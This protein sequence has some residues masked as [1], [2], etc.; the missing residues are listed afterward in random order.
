MFSK[1][2][3]QDWASDN[4]VLFAS[5]MTKI[6][7]RKDDDLLRTYEFRGFPSL[8]ILDAEGN[9]IT[10]KVSRDLFSMKNVVAAAPM[11]AKIKAEIDDGKEIDEK[12]WFMAQLAMGEL[13]SNDVREGIADLGITGDE[14]AKAEEM[15]FVLEMGELASKS[16]G[17]G[18]TEADK[19]AACVA[20]YEAFKAGKRL[21]AGAAPEA[22]VD[23][24]LVDA[25]KD[26]GDKKAF[27]FAYDRVHERMVE[28]IA[29]LEGYLPRYRADLEKFKDNK[30]RVA[31]IEQAL[32]RLE[33]MIA[34]T[35]KELTELE[36]AAEKLR[37]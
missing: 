17:R 12:A 14:K 19:M 34:D 24:M 33:Q 36:A 18:A 22:F 21:P 37:S 20:V 9:A 25:A 1:Q 15:L 4:A 30:A 11:Y 32:G 8:A 2:D 7:G 10:K 29:S 3:F 26:S 27:F 6:E 31:R 28:R 5:V 16:R 23:E 35:K 13:D